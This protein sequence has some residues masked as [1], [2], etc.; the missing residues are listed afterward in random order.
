M[1]KITLLLVL[2]YNIGFAQD[3]QADFKKY[4]IEKD[5]LQQ[6]ATLKKWEKSNPKDAEL[7]TS[8]YNYYF[9]LS[10]RELLSLTVDQPEG[11]SLELKD[12][13]NQT[14][15]YIGSTINYSEIYLK[16]AFD[17]IDAGIALYPNRLDMRFGK[18]YG[19]GKVKDWGNFTNEIIKT[20]DY[21]AQNKNQWTW[22]NNVQKEDGEKFMLSS[23][24][25]YQLQL[26]N[27][28]NDDLLLNMRQIANEILKYYPK[29]I[30]SL[31]NLSIT[32]LLTNEFDKALESLL[33]AEKI[34][35]KDTVILSNI[36]HAY[37][38]KGDTGKAIAYYEKTILYGDDESKAFA[39][40]QIEKLK[41]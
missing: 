18:I 31:S 12:S 8:Y 21:S 41:K 11:E 9:S 23:F 32:Y 24:Q 19:L 13:T 6:Q 33:K 20:I 4:F 1:K 17:K 28:G 30:E 2:L 5:T 7:F 25:S 16:R 37:K 29:H 36:A 27:T 15:G 38:L 35:S 3:F 10:Q 26:Y 39:Q 22:T 14:A 40:D 34:D